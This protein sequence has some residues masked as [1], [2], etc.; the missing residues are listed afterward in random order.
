METC[1]RA[2]RV[3]TGKCILTP[4]SV[5]TLLH[6]PEQGGRPSFP[7]AQRSLE[8]SFPSLSTMVADSQLSME[9]SCL[10][11]IPKA[12]PD[13]MGEGGK[14]QGVHKSWLATET[15][16]GMGTPVLLQLLR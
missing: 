12:Q 10:Q 16:Q 9:W 14:A 11:I 5:A 3:T 2:H 1:K 8:H 13:V 6:N 15:G 7:L 4:V